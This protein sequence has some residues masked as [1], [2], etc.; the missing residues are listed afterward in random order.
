[1]HPR[2]IRRRGFRAVVG[3]TRDGDDEPVV[4][5]VQA[6]VEDDMQMVMKTKV[7]HPSKTTEVSYPSKTENPNTTKV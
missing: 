4:E 6:V 7:S 2:N 1:M 5:D 3:K